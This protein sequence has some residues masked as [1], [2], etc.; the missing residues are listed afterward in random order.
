MVSANALHFM[1][2]ESLFSFFVS[3]FVS[4]FC[5]VFRF[6][7]RFVFSFRF[8]LRF[9]FRFVFRIVS[10]S[11]RFV[12]GSFRLRIVVFFARD[13]V[14]SQSSILQ[15]ATPRAARFHSDTE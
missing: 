4:F 6:V 1:G 7:F 11:D 3:F 9:S 12:L 15:N 2:N 14:E 13:G 8:S 10:F 5:F